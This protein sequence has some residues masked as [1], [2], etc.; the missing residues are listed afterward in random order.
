MTTSRAHLERRQQIELFEELNQKI[1]YYR[2]SLT[3]EQRLTKELKDQIIDL[4]RD[5]KDQDEIIKDM[6]KENNRR[7]GSNY[8]C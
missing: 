5:V 1:K 7:D 4:N 8:G 6:I 3:E 2:T